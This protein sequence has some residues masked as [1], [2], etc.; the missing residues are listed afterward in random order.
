MTAGG[1]PAQLALLPAG[2]QH[3][4]RSL[5][6]DTVANKIYIGVGS[7]VNVG[8]EDDPRYAAVLQ[9]NLDGS[10]STIHTSGIRNPQGLAI[11]Y[12]GGGH[13]PWALVN[14]RDGIGDELVPDYLTA[15]PAAGGFYGWPFVYLR[16]DMPDPR[17]R[18]TDPR[19]ATT[20]TPEVLLPAHAAALGL[21]FY[22][23]TQFPEEYRGDAYIACRGS[24]NRAKA[25]GYKILRVRLSPSGTVEGGYEEFLSGWNTT[26]GSTG[27][28]QVFGR[29]VNLAIAKDGSLLISDDAGG[30]IWRLRY[31]G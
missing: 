22:T 6:I 20:R 3:P 21:L 27:T 5:A 26:E 24:W 17:I 11:N 9:F 25:S 31:K 2:G 8:I 19:V 10:G 12:A 23:G 28:P 14:E 7:T 4:A 15:L 13:T 16:A 18:T 1:G 29:P 30:A